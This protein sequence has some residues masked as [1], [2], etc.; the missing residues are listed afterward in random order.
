MTSYCTRR[1]PRHPPFHG[2]SVAKTYKTRPRIKLARFSF[3][4]TSVQHPGK[5]LL[6]LARRF[7]QWHVD[8]RVL[9]LPVERTA[10][11]DDGS[12]VGK[13]ALRL[14]LRRNRRI[15]RCR[16][17]VTDKIDRRHRVRARAYRPHQLFEVGY[18]NVVVDHDHILAGIRDRTAHGCEMSGL[19]GVP[20]ITLLD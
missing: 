3:L 5:H 16:P 7:G 12:A 11:I 20:W 8:D 1:R 10:G 14:F 15:E 4:A 19:A 2:S 18:I 6:G 13:V 17:G 9:V